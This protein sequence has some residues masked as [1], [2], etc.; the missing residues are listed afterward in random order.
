MFRLP[1]NWKWI[2]K[3]LILAT[4]IASHSTISG[5]DHLGEVINKITKTD[6]GDFL[7]LHRT[8]CSALIKAVIAP[9]LLQDFIMELGDSPFSIIV[10]ESTDVS[11]EKLLCICVKFYSKQK[12]QIITQFLTFISV[13]QATA[14]NMYQAVFD[15]FFHK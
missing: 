3:E 14:E 4:Y 2:K 6:A 13:V 12:N 1:K 7:R 5:V 15:F 8:K 11:T 10:D 9:S